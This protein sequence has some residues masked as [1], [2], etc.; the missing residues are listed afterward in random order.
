MK[1][2]P[3]FRPF[4]GREEE[5]AVVKTLRSGWLALGPKTEEFERKFAEYVGSKYAVGLN[6]ATAALHLAVIVSGVKRGDEVIVPALTF[7]STAEAVLMA[8][9]TPVFADV[10][11][12][13]LNIDPR[14]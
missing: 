4:M 13:T 6:S 7:A 9:A 11:P 12:R 8:G 3:L 14:S 5:Q 1:K 2:I 10:D